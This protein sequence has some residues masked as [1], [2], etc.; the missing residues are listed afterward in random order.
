MDGCCV[1]ALCE[2]A[3]LEHM[4]ERLL[5]GAEQK[6][7]FIVLSAKLKHNQ[8]MKYRGE[9]PLTV[10]TVIKNLGGIG[11]ATVDANPIKNQNRRGG[12]QEDAQHRIGVT[13][14]PIRS[15]P[16]G[17]AHLHRTVLRGRKSWTSKFRS[18]GGR[19]LPTPLTLCPTARWSH[20]PP[21]A[22]AFGCSQKSLKSTG[23]SHLIREEVLKRIRIPLRFSKH[24]CEPGHAIQQTEQHVALVGL[25]CHGV[26]YR[27]STRNKINPPH[28]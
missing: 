21:H 27:A 10:K 1:N 4:L 3:K 13:D 5:A 16:H 28:S 11:K 20:P 15:W 14:L 18:Q 2:S 19:N 12:K 8:K 23:D 26:A 6:A 7:G 9:I 17:F 25:L 24:E 22:E